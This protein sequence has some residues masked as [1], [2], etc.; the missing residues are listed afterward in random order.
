MP[1]EVMLAVLLGALMH[2]GWNAVVKSGRDKF[3]DTVLVTAGAALLAAVALPFLTSPHPASWPFIGA[4]VAI[5]VAYFR[6]VAAA[7]QFGDMGYAYPLMRG[8]APLLV[9]LSSGWILG[10][11][12][13]PGAWAG[14][15]IICGGVLGLALAHRRSGRPMLA[16]TLF[17]LANAAVIAGYTFVDG[18]GVRLS[19]S[20]L[21]YT[22]WIFLLCA[23]FLFAWAA[24]RRPLALAQHL[25]E[26]WLLGI[27]GGAASVA[28]YALALWA[29]TRAPVAPVAA[30]REISIIFGVVIAGLLLREPFGIMRPLAASAV[31]AGAVT[32]RLA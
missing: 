30:L 20:A 11:R 6:L 18:A 25:R 7:Y 16:T 4:S 17:A 15:L 2:A 3:L 12:L 29:M 27:G 28:S 1:A 10:E 14:V 21:A 8:T 9:A 32:L 19:G 5:H 26:R 13:S 23:I 31:V 22:L 24:W